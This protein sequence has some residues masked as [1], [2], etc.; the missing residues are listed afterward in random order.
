VCLKSR[1]H[2]LI[3]V[4]FQYFRNFNVKLNCEASEAIWLI[5]S[6]MFKFVVLFA[7]IRYSH[8]T[9]IMCNSYFGIVY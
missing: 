1:L 4:L 8:C 3:G 2:D 7:F 9:E 6:G 5:H